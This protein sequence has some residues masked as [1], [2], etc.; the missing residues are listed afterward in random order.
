MNN[1]KSAGLRRQIAVFAIAGEPVGVV[2]GI[3]CEAQ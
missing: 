1:G 2:L 3:A